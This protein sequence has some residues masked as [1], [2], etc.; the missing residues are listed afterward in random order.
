MVIHFLRFKVSPQDRGNAT[1]TIQSVI[2]PTKARHECLGCSLFSH[3]DNDDELLLVQKWSSEEA[4]DKYISSSMYSF[5]L[6]GLELSLEKPVV[7]VHRISSSSGIEH[8][9]IIRQAAGA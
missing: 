1:R 4:L 2:G 8:I 9:E 5:L 3:V 6:E 7:E